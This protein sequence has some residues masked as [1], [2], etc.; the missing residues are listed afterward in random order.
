MAKKKPM[1]RILVLGTGYVVKPLVDY[2]IEREKQYLSGG[3][4]FIVPMPNPRVISKD[5]IIDI[6]N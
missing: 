5:S 6:E 2:F 4:K 1:K 3:G